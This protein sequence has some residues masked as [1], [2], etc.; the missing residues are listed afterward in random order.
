MKRFFII[1]SLL[2][3]LVVT[4]LG[5]F[6]YFF[7]INDHAQ[8]ITKQIEKSTGYQVNFELIENSWENM[9]FSVTGVSVAID[10]I[11]LLHIDKVNIIIS[12]L[13]LWDQNLE[14][15]LVELLGVDLSVDLTTV[16]KSV[17]TPKNVIDSDNKSDQLFWSKLHLNKLHIVDLNADIS[18][19][20]Q[21]LRVQKA[22]LS[23]DDVMIIDHNK[24]V[25][26]LLL[27]GNLQL[28]INKL[29]LQLATAETLTVHDLIL[30]SDFDMTR[31]QVQLH[32]KI[33]QLALK[34]PEQV[35]VIVD[36]SVLQAQ[37]D[38]NRVSLTR[39]S[40]DLFSG[41][42]TL[43][44][45]AVLAIDLFP[46][47]AYSVEELT[48]LS[49]S[50]KDMDIKIPAFMQLSENKELDKSDEKQKLPIKTLL[51]KQ[52]DLQNI[53]ISSKEKQL[54]LNVTGLNFHLQDFYLLQNSQWVNLFDETEQM[55]LFELQFDSLQ[56]ED[57]VSKQLKV[58][59]SFSEEVN[60]LGGII[61]R[62]NE[63]DE[64][65]E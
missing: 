20:E 27:K 7:D 15:E 62:G 61:E 47:P 5:G 26:A 34:L 43:Q 60:K 56:W 31:L 4:L 42:L 59:G 55:G 40:A 29:N 45:D 38:K 13:D 58:S 49:L 52:I 25:N 50:L 9:G 12:E 2:L 21:R 35:E 57:I 16:K 6:V 36:N 22:S 18:D 17:K 46:I 10:K 3:S 33:K 11:E 48:I 14:V 37:L 53:A 44:A 51:L 32:T 64:L 39:L 41:E 1:F 65:T 8:W 23:S 54:P 63:I 28:E 24:L 30:R 19:K